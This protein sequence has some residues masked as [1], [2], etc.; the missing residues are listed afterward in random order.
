MGEKGNS[1]GE[2]ISYHAFEVILAEPQVD[3]SQVVAPKLM[4]WRPIQPSMAPGGLPTP[5][6]ANAAL[7]LGAALERRLGTRVAGK[8]RTDVP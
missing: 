8:T 2:C 3:I 4:L 1:L 5:E 6:V 7:V